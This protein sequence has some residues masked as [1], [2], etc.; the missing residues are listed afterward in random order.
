MKGRT[1]CFLFVF[2]MALLIFS[3]EA[4][5]EDGV[6]DNLIL[7]GVQGP[8][9]SFS[10]DEENFG[11]ELGANCRLMAIRRAVTR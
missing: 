5:A 6:T 4:L 7:I 10:G 8:T 3:H 2:L 11:M 1:L 9:G